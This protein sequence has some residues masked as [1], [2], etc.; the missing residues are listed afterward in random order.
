MFFIY[1]YIYILLK[2]VFK[3][4]LQHGVLEAGRS[5]SLTPLLRAV[6]TRAASSEPCPIGFGMSPGVEIS[7]AFQATPSC[8]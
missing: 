7:P 4:T 8:V 5:S 3:E 2:L 6:L 1:I